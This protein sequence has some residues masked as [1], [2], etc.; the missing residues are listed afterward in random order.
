VYGQMV[1]DNTRVLVAKFVGLN[2]KEPTE[3]LLKLSIYYGFDFRFCNNYKAHENID[4]ETR[5]KSFKEFA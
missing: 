3:E 2:E 5:I 1:Y 4:V